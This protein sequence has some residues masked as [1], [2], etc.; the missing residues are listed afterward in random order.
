[1]PA[2]IKEKIPKIVNVSVI[3]C[4]NLAAIASHINLRLNSP[5]AQLALHCPG[6]GGRE[7][8]EGN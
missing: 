3:N 2:L 6:K 1:M 5:H 8:T 7:G 4:K